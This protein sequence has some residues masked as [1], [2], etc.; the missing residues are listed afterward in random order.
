LAIGIDVDLFD[1]QP[2][3]FE[4]IS[5]LIAQTATR[6]SVKD[7]LNALHSDRCDLLSSAV[8]F[9]PEWMRMSGVLNQAD[10]SPSSARQLRAF[11]GVALIVLL[12]SVAYLPAMD[13]RFI[14]DDESLLANNVIVQAPDGLY[15]IWLTSEAIDYW[16]VTNTSFWAEWRLW[17][18]DT[19]GY[20]LTNLS[21]HAA[22]AI[23]IWII[24]R[25][26]SIPGSFLAAL[27]FSVHPVNVESVAW[28]AERKNMLAMVLFLVSIWSY[29]CF[30]QRPRVGCDSPRRKWYFVS[31]AAFLLAM[32]SKGSVAILPIVLLLLVWWQRRLARSDLARIAP[33]LAIAVGLTGVNVWF[34]TRGTHEVIRDVTWIQRALGAGAVPWFY[35]YKAILPINLSFVYPQWEVRANEVRW[36]LPLTASVVVTATLIWY[37]DTRCGRPLLMTW[38]Y[39]CVAL[40]PVCGLVDVYFMKYSL[41]ADHYQHIAIAGLTA[42][43]AA[44]SFQIVPTIF[45][46]RTIAAGAIAAM[47]L[48]LTYR[49][50]GLY[51]NEIALYSDALEKNPDAWMAHVNLGMALEK[52]GRTGE[53]IEHY[54]SAVRLAPNFA[55]AWYDLGVALLE[56]H[57]PLEAVENL[58]WALELSPDFPEARNNLGAALMSMGR[59]DEAVIQFQQAL[60]L[61][62]EYLS[63]RANLAR[64]LAKVGR[65]DQSRR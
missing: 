37:R 65:G 11:G 38:L 58:G 17:G 18:S 33:F 16:P 2:V 24:L 9:S 29:L 13:G 46:T 4:D 43:F 28:I 53:A 39:Y 57:K 56:M 14:W 63:A 26:L 5:R 54:Q 19:R 12:T 48:V 64:A 3:C 36:W 62:P 44:Y 34:Q 21:L 49:Q 1:G 45:S 15:R 7:S 42:L 20:H 6:P 50:A 61:R 40:L 52:S 47:L 10:L 51:R 23:L 22:A 59:A 55:P 60:Q 35:L 32:L 8:Q 31:L 41:V 27:L 30:Q 25:R